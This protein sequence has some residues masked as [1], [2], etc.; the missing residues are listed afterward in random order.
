MSSRIATALLTAVL[1]VALAATAHGGILAGDANAMSFPYRNTVNFS[2]SFMGNTVDAD[3]DFAVYEPG[4]FNVSFPGQDPSGDSD[5][6]YAYQIL[7]NTG[8]DIVSLTVGLDGLDDPEPLG[9]VGFLAGTG[10]EPSNSYFSEPAPPTSAVWLFSDPNK[11][12]G[13]NDPSAILIFTSDA[14]P[15]L[16]QATLSVGA[17]VH[18][19]GDIPSPAP[20]P[21]SVGLLAAG[22]AAICC[23]RRR[24]GK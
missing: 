4:Q 9:T 8:D 16:D 22:L 21:A 17:W 15:E 1:T 18:Q 3:L 12:T 6:V 14:P 13:D 19:E 5:Y 24:R 23:R 11:L 20:E 10:L 7:D 2:S